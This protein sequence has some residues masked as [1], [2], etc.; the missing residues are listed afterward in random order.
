MSGDS[1]KKAI[2]T[3]MQ[4]AFRM[5]VTDGTEPLQFF[6]AIIL[7]HRAFDIGY[8]PPLTEFPESLLE[9]EQNTQGDRVAWT[10]I[11]NMNVLSS[12]DV[13]K[14]LNA[15]LIGMLPMVHPND[16]LKNPLLDRL[17]ETPV[18]VEVLLEAI[19]FMLIQANVPTTDPAYESLYSMQDMPEMASSAKALVN[20]ILRVNISPYRSVGSSLFNG[21]RY[22]L[23]CLDDNSDYTL[24]MTPAELYQ[25]LKTAIAGSP[26]RFVGLFYGQ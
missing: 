26:V 17:I 4:L 10:A 25:A 16:H 18:S 5:K 7:P 23:R 9:K 2:E 12:T 6:H 8:L 11:I 13:T 22:I 20:L 24:G 1:A 21:V 14:S 19:G 15:F 3:R